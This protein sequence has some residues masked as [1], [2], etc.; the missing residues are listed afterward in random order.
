LC[1]GTCGNG[2]AFLKLYERTGQT[3]WL[4]RARAFAMHA[5]AQIEADRREFN[6]PRLSLW[7]GD[8][9]CAI[10][11]WDCI[12]AQAAFPMLEVFFNATRQG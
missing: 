2:Y 11:L 7:T 8:L 12:R 9:G 6:Q 5:I 1:H 10:Y 3:L 4:D